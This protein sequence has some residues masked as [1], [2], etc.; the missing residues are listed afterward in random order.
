MERTRHSLS[1]GRRFLRLPETPLWREDLGAGVFISL[2]MAGPLQCTALDRLRMYRI[3]AIHLFIS[4]ERQPSLRIHVASKSSRRVERTDAHR[5]GRV[6]TRDAS[7][8]PKYLRNRSNRTLAW[9]GCRSHTGIGSR[10]GIH[11]LQHSSGLRLPSGCLSSQRGILLRTRCRDADL[12]LRLLGLLRCLLRGS[13]GPRSPKDDSTRGP[14][15]NRRG[16]NALCADEHKR[17]WRA[18][19]ARDGTEQREPCP[20]VHYGRHHGKTI[21]TCRCGSDCRAHLPR[22][23]CLRVCA[24]TR[25]FAD[26]LCSGTG[27]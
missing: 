19:M 13:R 12:S 5:N 8:A 27:R 20:H 24:I 16:R 2:R 4:S 23:P 21:W 6:R 22:S 18:P 17:S 10:R 7:F 26:S 3:R 25:I 1:R 9:A 14:W 15:L 11:A